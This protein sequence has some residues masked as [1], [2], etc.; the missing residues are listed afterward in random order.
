MNWGGARANRENLVIKA[1]FRGRKR[2]QGHD[3]KNKNLLE[4]VH[5]MLPAVPELGH[6]AVPDLSEVPTA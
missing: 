1:C 4:K 3:H 2:T 6:N 5:N